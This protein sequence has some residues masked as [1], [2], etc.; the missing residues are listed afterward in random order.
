MRFTPKLLLSALLSAGMIG[1]AAAAEAEKAAWP[2]HTPDGQPKVEGFWLTVVYGMGCLQNPR[3]GVGC[4]EEGEEPGRGAPGTPRPKPPKAASRIIDPPDGEIPY[5]P[6]AR[7]KQQYYL[8]NYF[9]P[10]RPEFLDPQQLCL[11]LGPVRQ[12]TWHDVHILQ[13]PG[14]VLFEHEGGHVFRIIPLDD[15]PH[16]GSSLKLW[17]G[18]SRGHWDGNTLVVDVTN[19]NSKGR[20]SRAGDFA[21]DKLHVTERFQFLDAD[22][23]K[24][25]A[26]FDDPSTYTRPWTFGFDMK[27]AIFGAENPTNDDAHYE[28][29]EEACYEGMKPVD[30]S[31]RPERSA[32]RK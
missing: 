16:I 10:T 14:Y 30:Y 23:M 2:Q 26:T 11:P 1:S 9:E 19:N 7:I 31:L 24:Y 28:Q 17:M 13:Y 5:Q 21:S 29:W 4:L 15:R 8:S 12:L 20:L 22:H 6:W 25:A 18:D 27:R 3:A 32:E